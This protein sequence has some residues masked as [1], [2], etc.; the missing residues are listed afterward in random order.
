V[1]LKEAPVRLTAVLF[2]LYGTTVDIEVDENSPRLW[3]GLAAALGGT[4]APV[5]A[6]DIRRRFQ[7][8]L[9][10]EGERGREGFLMEPVFRR[11][12]KSLS[13]EGDV[14]RVGKLF[15]EL[16]LK[17]MRLRPYVEPLFERLHRSAVKLGIV[18]NTEAVLTRFELDSLPILQTA[19]AIVLSSDVGIRKPDPEIFQLAIN[20]ICATP[21]TTVFIGNDW[22]ADVLGARRA[23]IRAIYL[24]GQLTD[25]FQTRTDT[26]GVYEVAPTLEAISSALRMCGWHEYGS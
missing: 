3:H 26:W 17:Q 24:N 18:S 2:D 20:R 23:G 14:A 11:L 4:A 15:R 10:E 8:F 9:Q 13:I 19:E 5:E 1:S 16:S 25:G 21:D 12:L 22:A 7:T 6:S